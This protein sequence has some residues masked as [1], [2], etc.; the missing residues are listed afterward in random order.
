MEVERPA[1]VVLLG[2]G[3]CFDAP[4]KPHGF[5]GRTIAVLLGEHQVVPPGTAFDTVVEVRDDRKNENAGVLF[6]CKAR[7]TP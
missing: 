3:G 2:D 1:V 5:A 4:H 6:A 7:R